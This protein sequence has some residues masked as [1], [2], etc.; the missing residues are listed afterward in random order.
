VVGCGVWNDNCGG[1]DML[2][3]WEI[4]YCAIAGMVVVVVPFTIFWYEAASESSYVGVHG[5]ARCDLFSVPFS[6]CA[7]TT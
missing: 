3:V 6:G 2:L 4:V 1:L 5:L 7:R